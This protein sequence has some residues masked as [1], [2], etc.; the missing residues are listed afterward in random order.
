[1]TPLLFSLACHGPE[2]GIDRTELSGVV[3]IPPVR[4]TEDAANDD[5]N[6]LDGPDLGTVTYRQMEATGTASS[7]GFDEKKKAPTGDGDGY[8]FAVNDDGTSFDITL[9]YPSDLSSDPKQGEA[10]VYSVAICSLSLASKR[11]TCGWRDRRSPGFTIA[12]T[13]SPSPRAPCATSSSIAR[14]RA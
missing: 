7:F 1:M 10:T 11:S 8:L 4:V 5:T 6:E 12:C 14:G 13:S 9:A 3:V 2:R